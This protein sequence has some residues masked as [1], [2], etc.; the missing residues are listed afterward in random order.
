MASSPFEVIDIDEF[1]LPMISQTIREANSIIHDLVDHYRQPEYAP[2]LHRTLRRYIE[3]L[4]HRLNLEREMT[5]SLLVDMFESAVLAEMSPEVRSS[6]MLHDAQTALHHLVI[7][8]YA[9]HII[10]LIDVRLGHKSSR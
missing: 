3:Q 2:E 10:E 5:A 9:H 1:I 6:T 4:G 7:P 8:R